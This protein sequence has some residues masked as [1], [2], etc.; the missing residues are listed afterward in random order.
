MRLISYCTE[1][2]NLT[3]ATDVSV[4]DFQM[5]L[6]THYGRHGITHVQDIS[7]ED[8]NRWQIAG[9]TTITQRQMQGGN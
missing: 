5:Y 3:M 8:F 7:K 2:T 1:G 4:F 6:L 9:G